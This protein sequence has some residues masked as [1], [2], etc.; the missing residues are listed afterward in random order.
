MY[1]RRQSEMTTL[2]L[3]VLCLGCRLTDSW[4]QEWGLIDCLGHCVCVC[5]C[6]CACV[7]ECVSSRKVFFFFYNTDLSSL[8]S[9]LHLFKEASKRQ[10]A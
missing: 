6:V 9:V 7:C 3:G 2:Q 5:V 4:E 10:D 1:A 8:Y